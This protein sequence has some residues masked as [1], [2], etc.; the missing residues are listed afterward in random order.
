MDFGTIQKKLNLNLYNK[1]DEF[2]NDM[3]LVFNNC[4]L[5]NGVDSYVGRIGVTVRKEYDR[6]LGM[7]NFVERF[8][9]TPQT[10]FSLLISKEF[11]SKSQEKEQVN[12]IFEEKE[13]L[14][15]QEQ[16]PSQK[17]IQELGQGKED[18]N[19]QEFSKESSLGAVQAESRPEEEP[20][21]TQET[22]QQANLLNEETSTAVNQM[23]ESKP[24][25]LVEH[26][27]VPS[28]EIEVIEEEE[29]Q[30]KETNKEEVF[31]AEEINEDSDKEKSSQDSLL[32]DNEE[33]KIAQNE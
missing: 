10:H 33:A 9:D 12:P 24:N 22:T 28:K 23:E 21:P 32:E 27:T 18:P 2:L 5:Y 7:Y 6:L 31:V 20:L 17:N 3:S 25:E 30:L 19:T 4:R 14:I 13:N 26:E 29:P 15:N 11:E 16:V 1:V 8:Q